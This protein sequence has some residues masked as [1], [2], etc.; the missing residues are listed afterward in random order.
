MIVFL[1][2]E[3]MLLLAS[4]VV[5]RLYICMR[6]SSSTSISILTKALGK[7]N[8]LLPLRKVLM[9]ADPYIHAIFHCENMKVH[10]SVLAKRKNRCRIEK[11]LGFHTFID[12]YKNNTIG[13]KTPRLFHSVHSYTSKALSK[14]PTTI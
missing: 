5:L 7:W 12:N 13:N 3:P 1:G 14:R 9:Q 8:K 6:N 2:L 4:T 11:H 10:H